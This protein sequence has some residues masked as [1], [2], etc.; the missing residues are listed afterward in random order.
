MWG[1]DFW[2]FIHYIC[3]NYKYNEIE[4]LLINLYLVL[5]CHLCRLNT[6][7][8]MPKINIENLYYWSIDF[9]NTINKSLDK[10]QYNYNEIKIPENNIDEV[11]ERVKF[12]IMINSKNNFPEESRDFNKIMKYI[13]IID[14]LFGNFNTKFP[15]NNKIINGTE[16][17]DG[18][19]PFFVFLAYYRTNKKFLPFCGGIIISPNYILTAA[20]CIKNSDIDVKII[21]YQKNLN[22]VYKNNVSVNDIEKIIRHP[23]YIKLNNDITLI[24]LKKS[25]YL[26]KYPLITFNESDYNINKTHELAGYGVTKEGSSKISNKLLKIEIDVVNYRYFNQYIKKYLTKNMYTAHRIKGKIIYDSCQGDSGGGVWRKSDNDFYITGIVSWGIGC[27]KKKYP[28]VY[29]KLINYL[30]WV[31]VKNNVKENL[32]NREKKILNNYIN[33]QKQPKIMKLLK[34]LSSV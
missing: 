24:K 13:D 34:I 8:H 11:I 32:P 3:Y 19:F 29:T 31:Y 15:I 2:K 25:I 4:Y 26:D 14:K 7:K 28:G 20:H 33:N 1:P 6:F 17:K 16:V 5:P 21:K 18:E 22:D 9:H 27:A 10:I 30:D 23:N 12:N